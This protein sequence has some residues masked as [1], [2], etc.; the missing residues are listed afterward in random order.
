MP[1]REGLERGKHLVQD[2]IGDRHRLIRDILEGGRREQGL[3]RKDL[4]AR[5]NVTPR[6][7]RNWMQRPAQLAA[8]QIERLATALSLSVETR[9][10]LYV[11]TDKLPPPPTA[12][13]F[14]HTPEMAVYQ[15][16]IDGSTH[17]TLV[18]DYA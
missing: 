12:D 16:M 1:P 7:L 14:R 4:A 2:S 11:L 15:Q 13:E 6:T 18:A 8:E 17:P 9:A 5:L 10:S 3:T